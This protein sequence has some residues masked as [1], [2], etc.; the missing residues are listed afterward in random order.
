MKKIT[1]ALSIFTILLVFSFSTEVF[2]KSSNN[3]QPN[4]EKSKV[5]QQPINKPENNNEDKKQSKNQ[6]KNQRKLEEIS[7]AIDKV[8]GEI[9][10]YFSTTQS[11]INIDTSSSNTTQSAI[12]IEIPNDSTTQSAVTGTTDGA[13]TSDDDNE[14]E[15][16][17]ESCRGQSFVGKLNALNNRLDALKISS[18]D[19]DY[20]KVLELKDKIKNELDKLSGLNSKLLLK[21]QSKLNQKSYEPRQKQVSTNKVWKVEFSK[22]IDA[23]TAGNLEAFVF[24]S[25]NNLLNTTSDYNTSDGSLYIKAGD[26]YKS[27]EKYTLYIGSK[28][29]VSNQLKNQVKMSFDIK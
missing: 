19:Q 18:D 11:A 27:G 21:F 1:K 23:D 17:N 5:E 2:A 24:D 25:N 29:N 16:I 20:S 26:G 8:S 9:D 15:N 7:R 4:N 3:K 10:R 12:D 6:N 14:Q 13:I 28:D 22:K